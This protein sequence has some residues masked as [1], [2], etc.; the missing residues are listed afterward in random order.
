MYLFGI[1][2]AAMVIWALVAIFKSNM[3]TNKKII[4]F[5]ISILIVFIGPILYYLIGRK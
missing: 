5:V 1:I 3:P 2:A 4:W